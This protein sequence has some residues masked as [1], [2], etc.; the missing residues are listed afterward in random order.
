MRIHFSR[1]D[2]S[3]LGYKIYTATNMPEKICGECQCNTLFVQGKMKRE[4]AE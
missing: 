4:C 2:G 3:C 1:F